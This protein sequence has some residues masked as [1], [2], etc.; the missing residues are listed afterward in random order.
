METL[1]DSPLN[2]RLRIKEDSGMNWAALNLFNI[3]I[4]TTAGA[5]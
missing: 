2:I 5:Q 1:N 4:I 3:P